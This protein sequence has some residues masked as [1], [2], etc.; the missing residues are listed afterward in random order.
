MK[1]TMVS[2]I[3]PVYNGEKFIK[4]GIIVFFAKHFQISN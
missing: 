1:Q 4:E 2:V 3:T